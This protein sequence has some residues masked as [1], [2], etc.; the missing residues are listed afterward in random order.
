MVIPEKRHLSG[1]QAAIEIQ[2]LSGAYR[3]LQQL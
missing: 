3:C 1:F 2:D